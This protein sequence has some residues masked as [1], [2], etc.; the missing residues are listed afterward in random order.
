MH[1]WFSLESVCELSSI[2]NCMLRILMKF[3]QLSYIPSG[4]II[5]WIY[6]YYLYK[7]FWKITWWCVG[8]VCVC[9]RV[10]PCTHTH[11]CMLSAVYRLVVVR[12]WMFS[13]L[14]LEFSRGRDQMSGHWV[15][16]IYLSLFPWGLMWS[17]TLH[18]LV[19]HKNYEDTN[20]SPST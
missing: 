3:Y 10:H 4:F 5:I 9:A 18:C 1:I 12:G 19:S 11:I 6:S 7:R 14:N 2:C 13:S 15:L 16:N 17:F 8:F 20:L